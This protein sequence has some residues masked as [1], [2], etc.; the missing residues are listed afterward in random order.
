MAAIFGSLFL[1]GTQ[2]SA[3]AADTAAEYLS[4]FELYTALLGQVRERVCVCVCVRARA[5]ARACVC[6]RSGQVTLLPIFLIDKTRTPPTR[7][8]STRR[9]LTWS[10]S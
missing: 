2:G 9:G 4:V 8:C 3:L 6:S 1:D 5:R 7:A 10:C